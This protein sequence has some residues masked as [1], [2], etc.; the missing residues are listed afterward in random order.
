MNTLAEEKH[1]SVS[2]D[3][4]DRLLLVIKARWFLIALLFIYGIFTGGAYVV[5]YLTNAKGY[6][7]TVFGEA[8]RL[9]VYPGLIV[10]TLAAYNALYHY[11]WHKLPNLWTKNIKKLIFTQLAADIPIVLLLIH[12]T[13]GINS[14]FWTLFLVI[15]LE[16]TYLLTSNWQILAIGALTG[17]GFSA[18]TIMEYFG[19]LEIY[20]LPFLTP[21]LN[22][23]TYLVLM[24]LWVNLISGFSCVVSVF[25]HQSEHKALKE[26][27]IKDELTGLYNRRYF[28][29]RL[30]SEIERAK[31]YGRV[32][33]VVLLD[34]DDF[35]KYN[36]K[37]GHVQGDTLLRWVADIF[38]LNIRRGGEEPSYD[39]DIACRYGG[40]E[41]TIILP[42][43][44]GSTGER[45]LKALEK[46]VKHQI[47]GAVAFTERVRK[48]IAG[49]R[50]SFDETVTI[51]A[52]IAC[53]PVNGETEKEIIEA[54][55][56]ALYAAKQTGKNK[57]VLSKKEFEATGS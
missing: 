2:T 21:I 29:Y 10:F 28:N 43:T 22:N 8:A 13:G 12:F 57:V 51:S 42:E 34:I 6:T 5:A 49:A 9:M 52:G 55:D 38:K 17:I 37:Y 16:L 47:S 23:S 18:L 11:S 15:N 54:A 56:K 45:S 30:S 27:I 50:T 41:F 48:T 32:L 46:E 26:R 39:I 44:S 14:W 40:E 1:P 31:R 36:D 7:P 19:V 4:R 25:L 20:E 35:K 24:L 53:Y 33:A 3:D